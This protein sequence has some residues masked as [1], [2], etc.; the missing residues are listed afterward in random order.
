M[1]LTGDLPPLYARDL[2]IVPVLNRCLRYH[3]FDMFRKIFDCILE[4]YLKFFNK[5]AQSLI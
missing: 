5:C 3:K 4:N 2:M 1:T